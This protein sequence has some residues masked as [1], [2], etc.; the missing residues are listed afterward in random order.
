MFDAKSE[1]PIAHHAMSRPPRKKSELSSESRERHEITMPMRKTPPST[2]T[3]TKMSSGANVTAIAIS[4][5]QVF[6]LW[7]RRQASEG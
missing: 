4:A 1:P 2:T 3:R 5:R 6:R 7:F